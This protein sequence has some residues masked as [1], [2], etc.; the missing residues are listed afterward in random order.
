MISFSEIE[1]L[2][3]TSLVIFGGIVFAVGH[4]F[5]FKGKVDD[6]EKRIETIEHALERLFEFENG[7]NGKNGNRYIR[8]NFDSATDGVLSLIEK[9]F[10]NF[11]ESFEKIINLKFQL[12]EATLMNKTNEKKD[13]K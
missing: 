7:V 2:T 6:H 8:H 5:Y 1:S 13:E 3:N 9:K 4:Y 10:V 12:L 11:E